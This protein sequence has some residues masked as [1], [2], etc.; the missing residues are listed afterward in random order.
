MFL[1]FMKLVGAPLFLVA[2]TLAARRWGGT[3]GGLIV[4]L[5]M[6]SGP[7]SVFL[8]L[9]DGAAFAVRAGIG[10][11]TGTLALAFFG[12]VYAVVCPK[13][14]LLAVVAGL[15]A[16]AVSSVFFS[17]LNLSL[18][19]LFTLTAVCIVLLGCMT[20]VSRQV[21]PT[22]GPLKYDLLLRVLLMVAMTLAVTE[23]APFLGPTVSGVLSSLPLMAPTTPRTVTPSRKKCR[24]GAKSD[25]R[26]CDRTDEHS[27]FLPGATD[28]A[29]RRASGFRLRGGKSCGR[30]F[31]VRGALY[32]SKKKKKGSSVE[33]PRNHILYG[34]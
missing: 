11:L 4:A 9:E 31:A 22:R 3:V 23:A 27:R 7:I 15:T 20:P 13:G 14:R 32:D 5:P 2:A 30:S 34:G 16:F 12:F 17:H 1:L 29:H 28:G 25:E 33:E 10:S 19:A 6:I 21:G 26:A 8:A 18:V 24:R